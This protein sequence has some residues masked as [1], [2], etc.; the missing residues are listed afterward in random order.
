MADEL[1]QILDKVT[2]IES[3]VKTGCP[4]CK[5]V[6]GLKKTVDGPRGVRFKSDVM[7]GAFVY[8]GGPLAA[9]VASAIGYLL[10]MG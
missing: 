2:T 10:Y 3:R 8:V 4:P 7:W 9:I 1:Q 6:V 5:T